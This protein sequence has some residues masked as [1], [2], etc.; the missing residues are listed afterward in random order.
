MAK[1]GNRNH[2]DK[3]QE[4]K[5]SGRREENKRAKQERS[6]KEKEKARIRREERAA[7][8]GGKKQ[9][10]PRKRKHEIPQTPPYQNK[11]P[12]QKWTSVMRKL[13]NYLDEKKK[14]DK[15]RPVSNGNQY[16][17]HHKHDD[18]DAEE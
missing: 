3:Y 1:A 18:I 17:K 8:N 7:E 12:I 5:N 13:D 6:E 14:T 4:Y 15:D 9:K 11:L 16:P 2:R 10:K